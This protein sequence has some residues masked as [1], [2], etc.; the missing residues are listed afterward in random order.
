MIFKRRALEA[1]FFVAFYIVSITLFFMDNDISTQ[2]DYNKTFTMALFGQR[3]EEYL[4][5][6]IP[7]IISLAEQKDQDFIVDVAVDRAD[8][9]RG[10]IA[11]FRE[12]APLINLT[13]ERLSFT[14]LPKDVDN[15]QAA[16]IRFNKYLSGQGSGNIR[17]LFP[18]DFDDVLEPF[19]TRKMS[20]TVDAGAPVA[21]ANQISFPIGD[22]DWRH[23]KS[24]QAPRFPRGH[25][26]DF[27]QILDFNMA[28]FCNTAL[29]L[30]SK[31][32]TAQSCD[33][34]LKGT[35]KQLDRSFFAQAFAH[36]AYGVL[37][38]ADL[39]YGQGNG[40][41]GQDSTTLESEI[42]MQVQMTRLLK[43]LDGLSGGAYELIHKRSDID[44]GIMR[45]YESGGAAYQT[46]KMIVDEEYEELTRA[47]F[48]RQWGEQVVPKSEQFIRDSIP[49][50]FINQM[51]FA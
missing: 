9:A 7:T 17:I 26:F 19:Y 8:A 27:E 32:F 44:E 15:K 41:Y 34:L 30:K 37:S 35:N 33:V 29:D 11:L 48:H 20:S 2:V 16:Y 39:G 24:I 10:V 22:K 31:F 47:G 42:N 5:G 50:H 23:G 28:G 45:I 40:F 25:K 4:R 18:A 21:I 36:G 12:H 49:Y 3:Y 51:H 14:D 6:A 13:N 46:Y 1:R 38:D 43:E